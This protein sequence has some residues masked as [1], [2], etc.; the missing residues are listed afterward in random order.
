VVDQAN[1][2]I[3]TGNPNLKPTTANNFDFTL[4]YN[5]TK[6]FSV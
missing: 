2:S 5:P 3:T 4:E 1:L 6:G